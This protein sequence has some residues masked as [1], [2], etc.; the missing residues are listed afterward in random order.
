VDWW[1][2]WMPK[3]LFF[4]VIG[5]ISVALLVVFKRLRARL[6]GAPA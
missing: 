2:D 4:L 5:L 3:Y 1:W 6:L